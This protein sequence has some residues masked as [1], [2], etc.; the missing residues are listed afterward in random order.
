MYNFLPCFGSPSVLD[1]RYFHIHSHL[2]K[3]KEG[4]T[5]VVLWIHIGLFFLFTFPK[6][7]ICRFQDVRIN[8]KK[9]TN[10]KRTNTKHLLNSE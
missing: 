6:L 7:G 2:K 8:K 3:R 4:K 9:G 5:G 1:K 10:V